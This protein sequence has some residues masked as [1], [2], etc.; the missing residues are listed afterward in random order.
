MNS[1]SIDKVKEV[2]KDF[3]KFLRDSTEYML[4]YNN[5]LMGLKDLNKNH[6][7]KRVVFI[8]SKCS[9]KGYVCVNCKDDEFENILKTIENTISLHQYRMKESKKII[10]DFK[11]LNT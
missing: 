11:K 3:Y 5:L 1:F 6:N 9:N 4:N 10:S 2:D 8:D 7:S